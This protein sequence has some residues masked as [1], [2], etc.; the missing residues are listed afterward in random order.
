MNLTWWSKWKVNIYE[1]KSWLKLNIHKTKIMASGSNTSWQI[2]WKTMEIVTDFIF[3][4]HLKR[5][6]CWER[7]KAGGEGD[8]RGWMFGWH[9]WLNGYEFVQ[10]LGVGD[11][12]GSQSATVHGVTKSQTRPND[13][14]EMRLRI[15]VNKTLLYLSLKS[16]NDIFGQFRRYLLGLCYNVNSLVRTAWPPATL[17]KIVA[18]LSPLHPTLLS[19]PALFLGLLIFPYSTY[20]FLKQS[21]IYSFII[22]L[23]FSR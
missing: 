4:T 14:T 6:W 11:G 3:L 13:S 7:L 21:H 12:Q 9:H 16:P 15:V 1:R 20:Y 2:D 5:P 18:C 17:F 19:Y 10:A 8:D 22:L 23:L